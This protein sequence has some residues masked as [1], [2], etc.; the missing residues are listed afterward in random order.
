MHR[1]IFV[2]GLD[3]VNLA[4]LDDLPGA[5]RYQFHQLLT[6]QE[7]QHGDDIPLQQLLDKAVRQLEDFDGQVDA[8][9][10]YWDFP[11]SSMVPILS[12]RLGLRSAS[13]ESVVK[14]EHKYWSRTEQQKVIDE[15][16][17]F[18]LVELEGEPDLP[19]LPLPFWLKPVKS[20]SSALAFR[21]D[22]EKGFRRALDEIRAGIDRVGTPFDLVLDHLDLPPE[23]AEAGGR[24][25]MAEETIGG[26]QVTVEGYSLDG[27]V[28]VYGAID[29][30]CYPETTSFLRFQYPSR[31]PDTVLERMAEVSRKVV[32]QLG[33]D[34]ATFNIE[35]FWDPDTDAISLLEVNPRHSQSH[36]HLFADVDGMANHK[37]MVELALGRDPQLAYREGPYNVAAKWF[38]RRFTD[39]LVTRSPTDEEVAAVETE[40]PGTT[41]DLAAREGDRLSEMWDQ[42]SY[43]YKLANIYIGADDE[44]E[45]VAKYERCV[46]A[47]PFSFDDVE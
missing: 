12:Q 41:I 39:G 16:P 43:S 20:F 26:Q 7:M 14:C 30:L 37:A 35:F 3:E 22:D 42:D 13:L 11:V 23:I 45:L 25:C 19:D 32:L 5:D 24:A 4:T 40:I 29:S 15:H 28:T 27:H 8:I 18:T 34:A 33:L 47:L 2:L 31:L 10:G 9:V 38:L 17:R 46:E 21:V 44:D 1:N 6:V 36:A